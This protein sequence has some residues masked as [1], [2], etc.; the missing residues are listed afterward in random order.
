MQQLHELL[1]TQLAHKISRNPVARLGKSPLQRNHFA[2]TLMA[3]IT[4]SP[5]FAC[6]HICMLYVRSQVAGRETVLHSQRIEERLDG[7]THLTTTSRNHIIHEVCIVQAAYVSLNGSCHRI[8]THKSCSKERFHVS[9]AVYRCHRCVH[10]AMICEYRHVS[11]RMERLVYLFV[12]CT[13]G[14]QYAIAFALKHG[15]FHNLIH[16]LLGQLRGERSI[17][18]TLVLL[19]ELRLQIA[20]H[21]SIHCLFGITL[22]AR[23]DSGVYLQSIGI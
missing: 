9:Y 19:E 16:L 12:A 22:H 18:F 6:Y 3:C 10:I 11:R 23:V 1:R 20:R 21:M 15:T 5:R 14:L 7:R 8:H 4:R 17:R 13:V 2:C